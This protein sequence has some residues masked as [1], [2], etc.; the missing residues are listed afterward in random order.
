MAILVR[1]AAVVAVLCA[2]GAECPGAELSN[3][4]GGS[5]SDPGD[6]R[7]EWH[8]VGPGFACQVVSKQ[9]LA[10]EAI[11]PETLARACQHMGSLAIGGDASALKAIATAPH[12]TQPQAKGATAQ[13]YFL[14]GPGRYP[15]LV[16][17]VLRD[18]IVALQVTGTAGSK[19]F[20]FNH[21]DLGASAETLTQYFGPAGNIR[22]SGIPD[23]YLWTYSPW[24]FS[25]EVKD[26]QVTSIR[27]V[28]PT[29]E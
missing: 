20:S 26:G 11:K 21:V 19:G 5:V 28:D 4:A 13:V 18:R 1:L 25:F 3:A 15:Y 6:L 9:R 2:Y 23:T 22:P 7:G 24:P 29:Y 17:T 14:D 10:P 27:I 8:R 12:D 16:A